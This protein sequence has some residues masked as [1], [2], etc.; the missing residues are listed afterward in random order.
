MATTNSQT[1]HV[2]D[3]SF[4][5]EIEQANA[6]LARVDVKERRAAAAPDRFAESALEDQRLAEQFAYQ[7][8][9][10]AAP[11]VHQPRKVSARDGLVCANEVKSDLPVDLAAGAA[12]GD[13]KIVWVDLA[14]SRY[15]S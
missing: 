10:N 12:P 11:D 1:V 8:T 9:G 15:C 7:Q 6:A 13:R 14:H 3:A 2:T 5:S 4:A